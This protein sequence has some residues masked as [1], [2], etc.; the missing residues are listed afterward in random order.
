MIFKLHIDKVG[1][2]R[3][4]VRCTSLSGP[5]GDRALPLCAF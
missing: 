1:T 4:A 2:N 3:R 5:L